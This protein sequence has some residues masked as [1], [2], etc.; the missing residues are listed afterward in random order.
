LCQYWGVEIPAEER[1]ALARTAEDREGLS[2]DEVR[3]ALQQLGLEVYLFQGSLDHTPTGVYGHVDAGRPPL[4][5]LS[6]DGENHHYGLVLGYDEPRGQLILLDPVK[7]EI[8]VPVPTFERNWER[9]QRF[10]LLACRTDE[11][12]LAV[13]QGTAPEQPFTNKNMNP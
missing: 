4:V 6:S 5:M 7:G 13:G 8:L 9:C 2:G 12:Q 10:T 1:V 3:A 11:T